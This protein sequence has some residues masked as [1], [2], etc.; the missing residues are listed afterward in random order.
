MIV[1]R[2]VGDAKLGNGISTVWAKPMPAKRRREEDEEEEEEVNN[3]CNVKVDC[4]ERRRGRGKVVMLSEI[5]GK[6]AAGEEEVGQPWYP[7]FFFFFF[8]FRLKRRNSGCGS[9]K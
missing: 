2:F 5:W 3:D 8:H 4:L 1:N 7:I 6:I 9:H